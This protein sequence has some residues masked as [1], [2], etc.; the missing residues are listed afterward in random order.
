M[1]VSPLNQNIDTL[2]TN[3]IYY[4]DFYQRQYKWNAEPVRRLMDDVFYK[5]NE[6]HDK[7]AENQLPI[8][9]KIVKYSWYYLNT[10]V[11]NQVDG[12]LY[13]VD[14]QQRLTTITL[15]LIKLYHMSE[16]LFPGY[17]GWISNKIL[18]FSGTD[19]NF[20][21]DHGASNIILDRLFHNLPVTTDEIKQ[22]GITAK[23]MVDN[24]GVI[25]KYLDNQIQ[26]PDKFEAFLNYFIRRVVLIKLDVEQTDVPMVFEVINDRGVRLSSYEILKGKL[27]GQVDKEELDGLNLNE[28]WDNQVAQVNG[29]KDNEMDTFFIYYLKA[30]L[31]NTKN[32]AQKYD[33]DYHRVIFE[34]EPNSKLHLKENKSRVVKFIKE[35]YTYFTNLYCKI[36][37][38]AEYYNEDQPYVHYNKLTEMNTQFLLILSCCK[39]NDPEE[40]EKIKS[41]SKNLD[42]LF[43]LLQLQRRYNSN[44]FTNTIYELSSEIREKNLDQIDTIFNK[45]LLRLLSEKSDKP[46]VD[47]FS[48]TYFKDT[49]IELEKRFKRY[50]FA[51]IE[52]FLSEQTNMNMRHGLYNL[53]QNTGAANGFH[54]EHI[55]AHNEENY[56]WFNN[57]KE[58]FDRERN[59]LGGL[60]LMKGKDNIASNNESY[61]RKLSSYANTLYWNETLR[62]DTYKSKKDFE[63]FM[64]RTG[65]NFRSLGKYGPDELEERHQLLFKM[66]R[67]IWE[68]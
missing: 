21:M 4:I 28:T 7:Y 60:L 11:T 25:S 43:C 47:A 41:V 14:G 42:R 12:K 49:G 9:E 63:T 2:F 65:L 17:I 53:T 45:H 10:Y 30:K 8:K 68:A 37:A 18:G 20:W 58:L 44:D 33:K 3:E 5:F 27:L 50:F 46:R 54:I 13:I 29:F 16:T 23:N 52:K 32:V 24:Y 1:D 48:Y 55:L 59:R 67:M 64:N 51:R 34:S 57:D 35:D 61:S 66:A 62:E 31:A 36:L 6:E 39:I 22:L 26:A 19:A 15:I 40:A 56:S 38:L